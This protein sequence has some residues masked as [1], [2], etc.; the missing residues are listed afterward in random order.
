MKPSV[1]ASVVCVSALLLLLL[2]TPG[3]AAA[4]TS[5]E[6][7]GLRIDWHRAQTSGLG[8]PES[9]TSLAYGAKGLMYFCYWTPASSDTLKGGAILTADGRR[10]RHYDEARRINAI[11]KNLGPT[12]M[13][14]TSTGVYRVK[15]K[16]DAATILKGTPIKTISTDIMPPD[17]LIGTFKHADG[18]RAVMINNYHFAYSAWPTVSFEADE[19]SIV[20]IDPTSGKEIKVTD[21]SPVVPEL[22][23]SLDAGQGRLF[24]LPATSG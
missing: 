8:V 1:R 21:D 2:L 4:A 20:E 22:Q 14:L 3:L 5:S 7:S 16:D 24:L 10:T 23:L 15:P 18:R 11:V 9:F 17:F 6:Q 13:K 19:K 12:L